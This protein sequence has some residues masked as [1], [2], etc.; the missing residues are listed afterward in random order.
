MT[1]ISFIPRTRL[2]HNIIVDQLIVNNNN[3][4]IQGVKND[5]WFKNLIGFHATESSSPDV[6][7]DFAE[8]N[9]LYIRNISFTIL[10]HTFTHRK[11]SFFY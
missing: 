3:Q 11:F 2:K 4:I 1:D 6:M 8:G 5:S 9:T 7:H 10:N